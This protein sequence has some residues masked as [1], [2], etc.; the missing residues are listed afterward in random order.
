MFSLYY[1]FNQISSICIRFITNEFNFCFH[2][3]T[4]RGY[5]RIGP[6]QNLHEIC[7]FRSFQG[8]ESISGCLGCRKCSRITAPYVK[9][10]F[11]FADPDTWANTQRIE[12]FWRAM[13]HCICR[14][15]VPKCL[16]N[17]FIE[18]A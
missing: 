9:P 16:F 4:I 7:F 11:H 10:L 5:Y 18:T 15:G 13:K 6:P 1:H 2:C 3:K 17:V 12:S 14:D 8:R